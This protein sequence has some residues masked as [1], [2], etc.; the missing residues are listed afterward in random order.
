MT[1]LW[2]AA[3]VWATYLIGLEVF[4]NRAIAVGGT[5]FLAFN[6]QFLYLSGAVN[7]DVPAAAAGAVVLLLS[8]RVVAR[9][10]DARRAAWLG[11]AYGVALLTKT[12]LLP[13]IGVI[14]LALLL[15]AWRR[16]AWR[17]ALR[18][19][20]IV[21]GVAA[22][23]SGWW[24]VRNA[25]LY[26]EPTG[27]V[28]VTEIWGVRDPRASLTLALMELPFAWTT[29]WGRFGYGQVP[30]PGALYTLMAVVGVA[31]LVGLA[32][33]A[34]RRATAVA[35][36]K[37]ERTSARWRCSARRRWGWRWCCSSTSWS[38]RRARWG[39]STSPACRP[40]ACWCSRG[41]R[42]L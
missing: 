9:G 23:V 20:G 41:W 8:V 27:F 26:G 3:A 34:L 4:G 12:H 39:A 14:G 6:P 36:R 33:Y 42:R 5:A 35:S 28:R 32:L 1:T 19:L 10:L 30:L 22:L 24:F 18:A 37:P 16:R 2:G 38:A 17:Q 40:T 31:G 29:L 21:L 15:A 11:L 7:N 13:M 25:V